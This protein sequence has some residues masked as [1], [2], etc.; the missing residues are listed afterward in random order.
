MSELIEITWT[1]GSI[2]EA[3]MVSRYL[4]QE[5]LIANAQIIPWIESVSMLDNRL[6]TSQE[7]KIVYLTRR[8]KFD[9]VK[10]VI[11]QNCKYQIPEILFRTVEGGHQPFLDWIEESTPDFAQQ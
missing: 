10:Q 1:S 2:D 4:V 5:R 11:L 3:R 7:S 6:E 8:D 9:R